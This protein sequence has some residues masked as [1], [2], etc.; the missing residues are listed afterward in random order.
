MAPGWFRYRYSRAPAPE[1]QLA[2]CAIF[3]DEASYLAEWTSFHLLVGVERFY[4]YDNNSTDDWR[5][6]LQP[7]LEAGIVETTD[8]PKPQ[9]E[10]LQMSAYEHCLKRHRADTRWIAF[11][12]VDEFL[13]SPAGEP[14]PSVL[15][16]F[17]S[18]PGVLAGWRLYGTGGWLTRPEGL[19]TE[20]YV[21][22]AAEDCSSAWATKPI[23]NP[24]RTV[25]WVRSAHVMQHWTRGNPL[26]YTTT[27]WEDGTVGSAV[28][29]TP[30]K[31]IPADRLR[32][33]HYRS[34]SLEE[35]QAKVRKGRLHTPHDSM[36]RWLL[37]EEHNEIRDEAI[38]RYVPQLNRAMADRWSG[39]TR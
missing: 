25:P 5:A 15:I 21:L 23:V 3:K 7:E 27:R 16:R 12:D 29:P 38:L 37:R 34:K 9:S 35:A 14:L 18:W 31:P 17:A 6:A 36:E 26:R 24:H 22:R 8:W 20:S 33:N 10:R 13:F 28:V 1:V 4:L 30:I 32:I 19:V 2:V 11:I 39:A